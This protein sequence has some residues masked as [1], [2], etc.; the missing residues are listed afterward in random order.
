MFGLSLRDDWCHCA[1][2]ISIFLVIL[3][4]N[5]IKPGYLQITLV[6]LVTVNF[7]Y[8]EIPIAAR[9]KEKFKPR[10]QFQLFWQVFCCF[11]CRACESFFDIWAGFEYNPLCYGLSCLPSREFDDI[12]RVNWT[13][14]RHSKR[15][16]TR[17][18]KLSAL[19]QLAHFWHCWILQFGGTVFLEKFQMVGSF[20]E[21]QLLLFGPRCGVVTSI[22][23]LI[24][25][26]IQMV[27]YPTS[28]MQLLYYICVIEL[29][30]IFSL[31]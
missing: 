13:V 21:Q 1:L 6:Q 22:F 20:W 9:E 29:T 3:L 17:G 10:Y 25:Y 19:P 27:S 24:G 7:L 15:G 14:F 30:T 11:H 2:F 12:C 8:I 31:L 28:I 26:L 4:E 16:T 23:F 5:I 18:A